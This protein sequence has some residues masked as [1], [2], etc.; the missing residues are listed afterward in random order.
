MV[1][2]LEPSM[3]G[4]TSRRQLGF[5]LRPITDHLEI[6]TPSEY[7]DRRGSLYYVVLPYPVFNPFI[8]TTISKSLIVIL[9]RTDIILRK[10]KGPA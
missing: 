9:Q 7:H 2:S 1:K 6:R 3:H 5:Y 4:Y 10:N 8:G